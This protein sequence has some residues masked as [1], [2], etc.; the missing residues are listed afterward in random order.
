M[1]ILFKMQSLAWNVWDG[2]W[3]P[4]SLW[5]APWWLGAAGPCTEFWAAGAQG[6]PMASLET[7]VCRPWVSGVEISLCSRPQGSWSPCTAPLEPRAAPACTL[8]VLFFYACHMGLRM[9]FGLRD[10]GPYV[11]SSYSLDFKEQKTTIQ[12]YFAEEKTLV[13][14]FGTLGNRPGLKHLSDVT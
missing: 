6:L 7:L 1:V 11:S 14:V 4:A 10:I 3:E 2:P 13:H 5:P 12:N 9:S 8:A